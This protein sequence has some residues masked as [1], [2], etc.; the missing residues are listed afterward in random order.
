MSVTEL[1]RLATEIGAVDIFVFHILSENRMVNL[2][3]WGH[4]SGW[5]GNVCL[6]P[7]TERFLASALD[8]Q[9][10]RLGPGSPT[11]VF[12]PYWSEEAVAFRS[13]G[14]VVAFGGEGVASLPQAEIETTTA[15][16]IEAVRDV[17]ASQQLAAKLE[18]AEAD[19]AVAK[20]QGATLD[21]TLGQLARTAARA[22]SCEFGA[23]VLLGD[24]IQ[25]A[26]ADEGWRPIASRDE[27]VMALVPL[28]AAIG[29]DLIIEQDLRESPYAVSPISFNEG[30][31]SRCTAPFEIADRRGLIVV[32]HSGA[33]PRGFTDLCRTVATT[34][35]SRSSL[36]LS[37]HL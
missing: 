37:R 22:L 25:I 28:A 29:E 6:D 21:D 4:G 32:G 24:S 10:V 33:A 11:R 16:A 1:E 13:D 23:V 36:P 8:G 35:A 20:I 34:M 31:V 15:K 27:I 26:V 17:G 7:E 18:I 3:G 19:L 5:A 12:G 14:H 9:T 30:L 2:D